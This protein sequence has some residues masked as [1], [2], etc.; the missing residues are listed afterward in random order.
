MSNNPAESNEVPK[1]I[2]SMVSDF[3]KKHGVEPEF[4]KEVLLPI[5]GQ[6]FQIGAVVYEVDYVRLNPARFT[7]HP[8]DVPAPEVSD[9]AKQ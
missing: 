4:V 3:L 6:R 5:V 8:I 2:D 1:D 9:E 7:A